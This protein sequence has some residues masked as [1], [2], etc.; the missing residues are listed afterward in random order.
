MRSGVR[1]CRASGVHE[2]RGVR[3]YPKLLRQAA[4]PAAAAGGR[5]DRRRPER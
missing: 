1:D 4:E 3:Q 2:D 5:D